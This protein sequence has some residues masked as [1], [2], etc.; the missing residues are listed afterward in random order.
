MFFS[1]QM[2][3]KFT[4][5]GISA[6]FC[7]EIFCLYLIGMLLVPQFITLLNK[8]GLSVNPLVVSVIGIL[9]ITT[10]IVWPTLFG[11]SFRDVRELIG[12]QIGGLARF[13]KNLVIAPVVYL[14][15]LVAFFTLIAAYAVLLQSMDVEVSQGAHPIV[16]ILISSESSLTTVLIVIL[17]VGV[18]PFVEEI[19][20]RGALYTWMR[21]HLGILSS[22]VLSAFIFAAVHP[23]GLIGIAPLMIIGMVLALLREWRQSLVAPMVAHAC[24]NAGTLVMV[25]I[26]FR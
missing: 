20:F 24:F 4:K 25:L 23:Q 26:L 8:A 16:P 6:E 1:K 17:A 13:M 3:F 18:A 5:P 22:I 21:S 2:Q 12:F 10:V 7:L 11:V 19:M 15:S 14:G 9:A